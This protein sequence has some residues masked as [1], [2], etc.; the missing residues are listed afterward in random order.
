MTEHKDADSRYPMAVE[1]P[2]LYNSPPPLPGSEHSPV[3][4]PTS[5]M[6][7]E[8]IEEVPLPPRSG[9]I[10]G[11]RR[12]TFW[13]VC[14][15]LLVIVI[16]AAV[17]G[18]VAGSKTSKKSSTSSNAGAGAVNGGSSSRYESFHSQVS[19][20]SSTNSPT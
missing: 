7:N 9:K 18:G 6:K 8:S 5:L 2:T 19:S 11:L 17:G 1:N 14:G 10:L 12:R 3:Q 20:Q 4:T 15:I 13:I 16:G